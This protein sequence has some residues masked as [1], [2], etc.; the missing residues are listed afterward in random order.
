MDAM[1]A[2]V[3][4]GCLHVPRS[5]VAFVKAELTKAGRAGVGWLRVRG[6]RSSTYPNA[7][8]EPVHE[9]HL[10]VGGAIRLEEPGQ[11]DVPPG[12][13]DLLTSGTIVWELGA[14]FR[15]PSKRAIRGAKNLAPAV[16]QLSPSPRRPGT[17][18]F[19]E[20]FAGIGGFRLGLEA[21]GGECVFASELCA[22]AAATYAMNFGA[23]PSAG[24]PW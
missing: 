8:G 16:A 22:F 20:L 17:F 3:P 15:D 21:V 11:P 4:V 7:A 10:S 19:A 1:L 23:P 18:R 14:R 6:I 24:A 9:V 12:V 2:G 13:R 5:H